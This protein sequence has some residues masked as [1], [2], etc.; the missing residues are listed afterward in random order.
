M[1]AA[2][3]EKYKEA[4]QKIKNLVFQKIADH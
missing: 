2:I 1:R 4:R 3:A